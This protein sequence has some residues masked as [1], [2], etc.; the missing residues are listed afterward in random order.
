MVPQ[1]TSG[2]GIL[3]ATPGI[4]DAMTMYSRGGVQKYK[5]H[6]NP[7]AICDHYKVTGYILR[8]CYRLIGY[9]PGHPKYCEKK[10]LE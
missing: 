3:G 7:N 1:S 5:K 2:S 8:D 4:S 10:G 6:Y 9:P